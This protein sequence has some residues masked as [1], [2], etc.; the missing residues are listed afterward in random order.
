[1]TASGAGAGWYLGSSTIDDQDS[2]DFPVEIKGT[3]GVGGA[4]VTFVDRQSEITG[5]VTNDRSQPIPDYT[6]VIY[7]SDPRYRTPQSRRIV[8]TRPST[9]GRFTF[10]NLPAGEYRLA[11]VLDPEPG[12]W[13]DPAVLQ[14]MDTVAIRV[15]LADGEK[16]EQNLRVP[17]GG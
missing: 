2:L 10:R 9:D 3:Q 1:M 7:P 11:P 15:T 17:G 6:L 8:S 13:Y 14:Q 16:K 12:S 5:L 4:V